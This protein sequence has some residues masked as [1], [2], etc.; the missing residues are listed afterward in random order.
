MRTSHFFFRRRWFFAVAAAAGLFFLVGAR[1]AQAQPPAC[2]EVI[3]Q[4]DGALAPGVCQALGL[5]SAC[6]ATR[7]VTATPRTGTIRFAAPG[8]QARLNNIRQMVTVP[9]RGAAVLLGGSATNPVK[10]LVF[11]DTAT[12]PNANQAGRVFTLR[13]RNG[14]PV[15]ERTRSGMILQT[16]TGRRGAVVVNGVTINLGSTAYV[17]PGADVLF[18]Q[19]PRIDRRQGSRNR[20]APLCSGFDSDCAF[21]DDHCSRSD[22][23]VWGPFCREDS[24]PY[25]EQGL[26]RVTLYGEGEVQAGATDYGIERTYDLFGTQRLS[27]PGSYTFCWN[28]LEDGGTG[29]ETVVQARSSNAYVDHITLEYLG[30]DCGLPGADNPRAGARPEEMGVLSV[31]NVQGGVDVSLPDGQENSPEAGQRLRVYFEDGEAVGM[32]EFT[33]DAPYV[34]DSNLAQWATGATGGGLPEVEVCDCPPEEETSTGTG[35]EERGPVVTVT[36]EV[37]Y[38][39]DFPYGLAVEAEALDPTVGRANGAG[40]DYVYFVIY[41]PDGNVLFENDEQEPAYCAFGGSRPCPT[42]NLYELGGEEGLPDGAYRVEATAYTERG[43]QASAT[44]E[45]VLDGRGN[46]GEDFEPPAIAAVFTDPPD[47]FCSGGDLIVNAEVNATDVADVTL[48]WRAYTDDVA[49]PDFT[50]SPMDGGDGVYRADLS[51]VSAEIV[52]YY[53]SAR[54]YSGNYAETAPYSISGAACASY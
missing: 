26:Y 48:W 7:S 17:V 54:D 19:D 50:S 44:A 49:V 5:G 29:F 43:R 41:D 47:G 10:I 14:E 18:D 3:T 23:L 51:G 2:D 12:T 45:F 4:L 35:A 52:E 9:Q 13:A 8:D 27:L 11:G 24:Y 31:Y 20:S 6:L 22:R 16:P 25:I 36:A 28:G 30:R 37:L 32:D 34:V 39:G 42:A 33:T 53:V 15:C 1:P 38:D 21:G 46:A 40:I